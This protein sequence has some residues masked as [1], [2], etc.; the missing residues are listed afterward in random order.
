MAVMLLHIQGTI[1]SVNGTIQFGA[2]VGHTTECYGIT[3]APSISY[4]DDFATDTTERYQPVLGTVAYDD[5]NKRMNVTTAT[6]ANGKASGRLK[7]YKFCEGAQQFDVTLPLA[8]TG[9]SS[10]W[11]PI[12]LMD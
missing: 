2:G 7:S 9:I 12:L 4:A 10:V 8:Q 3:Y 1:A 6:G 11:S 5:A